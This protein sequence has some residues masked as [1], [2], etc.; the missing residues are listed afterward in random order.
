MTD[1][2][3]M[4]TRIDGLHVEL[5]RVKQERDSAVAALATEQEKTRHWREAFGAE[6]KDYPSAVFALMNANEDLLSVLEPIWFQAGVEGG[7]DI[8]GS[9]DWEKVR[10]VIERAKGLKPPLA[11]SLVAVPVEK[12]HAARGHITASMQHAHGEDCRG[13]DD[14]DDVN[15]EGNCECGIVSASKALKALEVGA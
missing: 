13:F 5:A 14:G 9:T 2:A 10:D 4:M 11:P 6:A 12:L 1:E 7:G 15:E 3:G 8:D